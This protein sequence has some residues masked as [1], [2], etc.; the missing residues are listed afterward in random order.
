MGKPLEVRRVRVVDGRV[1]WVDSVYH[2]EAYIL[3]HRDIEP[4]KSRHRN[5]ERR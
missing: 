3:Q 5:A 2:Q 1:V 4:S